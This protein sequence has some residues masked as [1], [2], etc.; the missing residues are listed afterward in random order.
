M[1]QNSLQEKGTKSTIQCI[2]RKDID[3]PLNGRKRLSQHNY[4]YQTF[5][6]N[7]ASA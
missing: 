1:G 5:V 6:Q 2:I 7:Q 4:K 3:G